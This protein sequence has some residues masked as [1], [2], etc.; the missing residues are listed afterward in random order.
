MGKGSYNSIQLLAAKAYWILDRCDSTS[1][2]VNLEEDKYVPISAE[3]RRLIV[4]QVLQWLQFKNFLDVVLLAICLNHRTWES[5]AQYLL[6]IQMTLPHCQPHETARQVIS[7]IA[8]TI[9]CWWG[10][11][12]MHWVTMSAT[13]KLSSRLFCLSLTCQRFR[14]ELHWTDCRARFGDVEDWNKTRQRDSIVH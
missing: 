7:G 8:H 6:R 9:V 12:S 13:S 1:S 14:Q 2:L 3:L 4:L 10:W 5:R 11:R